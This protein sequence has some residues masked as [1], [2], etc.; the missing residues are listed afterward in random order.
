MPDIENELF[1]KAFEEL[2]EEDRITTFEI[3]KFMVEMADRVSQRRQAANN[4]YL[5]V[6]TA[7]IG[8]AAY[9]SSS[10]STG[11]SQV[12]WVSVAGIPISYLWLRNIHS[13]KYLNSC[14]FKIINQIEKALPLAP[15]SVEGKLLECGTAQ[16]NYRPFHKVER[17]VPIVFLSMHVLLLMMQIPWQKVGIC[18]SN[19]F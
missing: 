3:Y 2:G 10:N 12:W 15:Y 9:I 19:I 7:L 13:Y 6:N 14:K 16:S 18:L 11:D 17:K 8:A 4:F 5:S 1:K